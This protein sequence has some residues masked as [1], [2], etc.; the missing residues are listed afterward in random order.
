MMIS[1]A[2][3]L[4]EGSRGTNQRLA[5]VGETMTRI[6]GFELAISKDAFEIISNEDETIGNNFKAAAVGETPCEWRRK[7][8]LS[9]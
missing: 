5:R 7:R 9:S 3:F 8:G 6:S 1:G 2:S 4:K